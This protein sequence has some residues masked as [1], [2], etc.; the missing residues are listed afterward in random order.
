ML[1]RLARAKF[2][3]PAVATGVG[4]PVDSLQSS[5][6]S[7]ASTCSPP[8][9]QRSS[10]ISAV[11]SL[12]LSS[13]ISS[14]CNQGSTIS[15]QKTDRPRS[16][17]SAH[18]IGG[19]VQSDVAMSAIS[20]PAHSWS[21]SE[22]SALSSDVQP[23][24]TDLAPS[25]VA[26]SLSSASSLSRL[27]LDL[28]RQDA[29]DNLPCPLHHG[30]HDNQ[31]SIDDEHCR[32]WSCDDY[33]KPDVLSSLSSGSQPNCDIS[34]TDGDADQ[35]EA[36]AN[37]ERL[38]KH[39]QATLPASKALELSSRVVEEAY[40][41]FDEVCDVFFDFMPHRDGSIL[42]IGCG[43]SSISRELVLHGFNAVQG[44]DTSAEA[45]GLQELQTA[46]LAEFVN[47]MVMDA[48]AMTFGD[49]SLDCVF[50]KA[51]LDRLSAAEVHDPTSYSG[52]VR[53]VLDEITRCLKPGG[54]WIVVSC[55]LN[56]GA[57]PENT[58]WWTWPDVAAMIESHYHI[59]R[60]YCCGVPFI[61]GEKLLKPFIVRVYRRCE[62]KAE[63]LT[64]WSRSVSKA[65]ALRR[66]LSVHDKW[67]LQKDIERVESDVAMRETSAM[68]MEDWN[69][70]Q[71]NAMIRDERRRTD[72]D[73]R[74]R[75][76]Y[77]EIESAERSAMRHEDD[78]AAAVHAEEAAITLFVRD[79]VQ[80]CTAVAVDVVIERLE[81]VSA[82][83]AEAEAIVRVAESVVWNCV[84]SAM[85]IADER[86][87]A[88]VVSST[89][90]VNEAQD[91][92]RFGDSH[93]DNVQLVATTLENTLQGIID[94]LP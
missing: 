64:R 15:S 68:V 14:T 62:T 33:I 16:S 91:I 88:K 60:A 56:G 4:T 84:A 46:E 43:T 42:D 82:G 85:I 31:A 7:L 71:A 2:V 45:I 12:R 24:D 11:S 72:R 51:C 92:D 90:S 73:A 21:E 17:A 8:N 65:Q 38:K 89:N 69:S 18:G 20:S 52:T 93:A 70:A 76:I 22:L 3:V 26:S 30:D 10:E 44:I 81:I 54:L 59:L 13:A 67:R 63:L 25:D 57:I 55:Q 80:H 6:S 87:A 23:S 39:S 40:V 41:G 53:Q 94:R 75:A 83:I 9:Q 5:V 32:H 61:V 36:D 19:E 74:R 37:A 66:Y 1:D 50:T 27:S 77:H 79:I 29:I 48:R 47:F 58:P 78:I 35:L 86:L 49:A 28:P 34:C